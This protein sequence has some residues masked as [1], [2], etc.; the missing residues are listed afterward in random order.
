VKS[1]QYSLAFKF[2]VFFKVRVSR[3]LYTPFYSLK[4]DLLPPLW[5]DGFYT[6]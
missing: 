3:L 5:G 4:V 1:D 2:V 6:I